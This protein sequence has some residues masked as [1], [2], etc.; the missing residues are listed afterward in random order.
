M[1]VPDIGERGISPASACRHTNGRGAPKDPMSAQ[2]PLYTLSTTLSEVEG[3]TSIAT[4][5]Q[6]A[7]ANRECLRE[8]MLRRWKNMQLLSLLEIQLG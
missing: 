3:G 5:A 1:S 2:W 4:R 6:G 8:F 7:V